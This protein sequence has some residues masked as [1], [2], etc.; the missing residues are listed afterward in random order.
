MVSVST[1]STVFMDSQ[2]PLMSDAGAETI[3]L[4]YPDTAFTA[5]VADATKERASDFGLE[6]IHDESFQSD[7]TDFTQTLQSIKSKDPD[8]FFPI[9]YA[10]NSVNIVS[11][12]K[13]LGII[14]PWIHSIYS[15][16]PEF[17]EGVG[18][19]A[20]YIFGRNN[21]HPN[22]DK[23][24]NLG[25]TVPEFFTTYLDTYAGNSPTGAA[26]SG[27]SS[28]VLI[29]ECIKNSDTQRSTEDLIEAGM[30]L[31]GEVTV[32]AAEWSLDPETQALDHS[33]YFTT[34]NLHAEGETNFDH[35]EILGPP[36]RATPTA[37]P[38]YPIPSWDER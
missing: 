1:P 7:T 34:Q 37:E 28:G 29:E 22:V 12:L 25:L 15:T 17:Y 35:F 38:I 16:T 23:G 21:I 19:D 30:D 6:V 10:G 26:A 9:T 33:G 14:F 2:L 11:Q 32:A 5:S 4:L 31:S 27:Y 24:V 18:E 36:E 13:N 20:Q 8:V 3:A